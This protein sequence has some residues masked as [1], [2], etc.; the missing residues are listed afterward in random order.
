MTTFRLYVGLGNST[1][2]AQVLR[3]E[4]YNV[5]TCEPEAVIFQAPDSNDGWGDIGAMSNVQEKTG[6]AFKPTDWDAI[7]GGK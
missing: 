4:G 2:Y 6:L 7:G 1:H 3:S 5:V